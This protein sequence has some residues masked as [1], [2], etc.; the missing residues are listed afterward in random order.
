MAI[1]EVISAVAKFF[2]NRVRPALHASFSSNMF[3][4]CVIVLGALE[5]KGRE[6]KKLKLLTLIV[7]CS[8]R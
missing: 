1:S 5:P 6:S 2:S 4:L 3:K 7:Y 8:L